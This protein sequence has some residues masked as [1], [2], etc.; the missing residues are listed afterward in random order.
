[1]TAWTG[2]M[3]QTVTLDRFNATNGNDRN[4]NATNGSVGPVQCNKWQRWTG[5][6]QHMATRQQ[7]QT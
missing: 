3:Q 6:M 2:S 7:I 1:M 5:S 4:F